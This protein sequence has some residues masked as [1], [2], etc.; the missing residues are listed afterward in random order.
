[1]ARWILLA[2]T[3]LGCALVFTT[4][5]TAVLGIGLLAAI[6]GFTGFVMV[7]AADRISANARPDVAMATPDDLRALRKP[8]PAAPTLPARP[9]ASEPPQT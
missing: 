8:T 5:N 1:M 3:I 4:H 7:L 2:L 9:R 6:V